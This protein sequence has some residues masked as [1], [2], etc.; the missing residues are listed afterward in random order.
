MNLAPAQ[1]E[2]LASETGFQS[3]P[4]EKV[5]HLLELLE[6][7]RSHPFLAERLA[8]KGGT[9]I[10]LFV[11]DLARLS[12]DKNHRGAQRPESRRPHHRSS[13]ANRPA[14]GTSS[15]SIRPPSAQLNRRAADDG[16]LPRDGAP[17]S[18]V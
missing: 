14:C 5:L 1:L 7:L 18:A 17:A 4:V 13:T 12:G 16:R 6:G 11:L 2:R 3:E 8:L 10:N 15:S 9:A